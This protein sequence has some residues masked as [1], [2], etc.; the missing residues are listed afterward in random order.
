M[1]RTKTAIGVRWAK[2]FRTA[3]QLRKS[4]LR[5]SED[6]FSAKKTPGK[7]DRRK[8][9][10]DPGA[11]KRSAAS[12]ILLTSLFHVGLQLLWDWPIGSR[13][14]SERGHLLEMLDDLP[15]GCLITGDAGFVGYELARAILSGGR[16]IVIRVGSN[17]K[18]LKKLGVFEESYNTVYLWPDKTARRKGLPPLVFRLVVMS[19]PKHPVFL[20]T[21]IM[22]AGRLSEVDLIRIHKARWSIEV[23]HRHLKQTFGRRKMLSHKAEHTRVELDWS[24]TGLW[25]MSLYATREFLAHD[26]AVDRMSMAG[27]LQSFRDMARDYLHPADRQWTLRIRL[28]LSL[29][30]SYPRQNKPARSYSRRKKHK[31]PGAPVIEPATKEERKTARAII[32]DQNP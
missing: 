26:I 18:L 7:R 32:K 20:I 24:V 2:R 19:G 3:A 1:T 28:R 6:A 22:D 29:I 23:Y 11:D 4:V 8:K 31:P 14:S 13:N 15:A 10:G 25:C 16:Q 21:N 27:V 30:D 5:A 12:Q 17:V 9:W